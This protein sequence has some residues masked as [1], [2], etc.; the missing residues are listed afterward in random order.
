MTPR[1]VAI[2][3]MTP[4]LSFYSTIMGVI[5]GGLVGMTQL[6]V[7]WARYWNYALEYAELRDLY[8][9]LLKGAVYGVIIATVS[10]H[11]GFNTTGGAVGVGFA[12]RRAVVAS[13]LSIL[14]AGYFITQLFYM[15]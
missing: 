5:G 14:V 2:V 11:Q 10:C 13:F 9:G 7:E 1:L 12:T 4:L 3:I 6:N 8:V 15:Q